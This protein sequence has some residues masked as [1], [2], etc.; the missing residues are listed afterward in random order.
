MLNY[1]VAND[2]SDW[3]AYFKYKTLQFYAFFETEGKE[4]MPVLK[5]LEKDLPGVIFGGRAYTWQGL[6]RKKDPLTFSQFIVSINLAKTGLPRPTKQMVKDAE[7]KTARH[8]IT[9][10][11]P[12]P[13]DEVIC[14]LDLKGQQVVLNK[15]A[16][17]EQLER[18]I[19]EVFENSLYTEAVHYEPFYPSTSANYNYSI[20]D[21]GAVGF[22]YHRVIAG[23]ED[24]EKTGNQLDLQKVLVKLSHELTTKYGES[25]REDQAFLDTVTAEVETFGV[26]YNDTKFRE[27]W[28]KFFNEVWKQALTEQPIVKPIGLAEAL[29]VRVISKGPPLLYTS[30][31]PMQK[32]MWKTLKNNFVFS[33]IGSPCTEDT[34][35]TVF[36]TILDSEMV[37]NGDYKA[38]TDNLHSWVSETL[39]RRLVF[40]LNRNATAH[41]A[42]GGEEPIHLLDQN[43]ED[44]LLRSL[45]GHLFEME[46]GSLRKQKEGQLMGSITSF[47]FLCLANAAMCRWA[48]ELSNRVPYRVVD[49]ILKNDR[50]ILAPLLVNGDDCTLKGNRKTIR[51]LWEKITAF[52]GLSSSVGKT[53]FSMPHR[54]I[55]VINSMTFD[56]MGDVWVYRPSL[57]L[58]L[59]LGYTRSAILKSDDC[60]AEKRGIHELGA[61]HRELKKRTPPLIWKEV[62]GRFIHH[63]RETLGHY[64][65]LPWHVPEYLGGVGL[66]PLDGTMSY[67]DRAVSS[68][69]IS[70]CNSTHQKYK[71]RKICVESEWKNHKL[72]ERRLQDLKVD[73][74]H[75][76]QVRRSDDFHL[77]DDQTT[78]FNGFDRAFQLYDVEQEYSLLYK[79]LTIETLFNNTVKDVYDQHPKD[80]KAARSVQKSI[81]H[82]NN[83]WQR[84]SSELSL[85]NYNVPGLVVR[86]TEDLLYETKK[87]VIPVVGVSLAYNKL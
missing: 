48:L 6:L 43:F 87:F 23:C 17:T 65:N 9:E 35:N 57:N 50:T 24:F 36:P 72:V 47:P 12:L 68:F 80:F 34:I 78:L 55:V 10:P 27:T 28:K 2:P 30:L 82:N 76:S 85:Q 86:S 15:R 38:S 39:A 51:T 62:S 21:G 58:G 3:M 29:K 19:D 16:M 41:Q 32:F 26:E 52:G 70:Q 67:K 53:L 33:L 13:G 75:F 54:P 79:Y 37:V 83:V 18:I 49:C 84:A 1:L 14:E 31:V 69:I 11:G 73:K 64:P 77:Y 8:L 45:T 44:M 74:C 40:I 66:V 25:G 7:Y 20:V 63:N 46:D 71:I 4:L 56:R 81:W 61:I 22:L 42:G 5:G 60:E 59:L